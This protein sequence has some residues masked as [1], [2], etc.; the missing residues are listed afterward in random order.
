M[1]WRV[2][3]HLRIRWHEAMADRSINSTCDDEWF[4]RFVYHFMAAEA[5]RKNLEAKDG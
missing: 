5:L 1:I 2:F 4:G 3:T